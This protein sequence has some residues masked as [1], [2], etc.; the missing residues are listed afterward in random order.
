[1]AGT[2][3]EVHPTKLG[4]NNRKDHKGFINAPKS[5]TDAKTNHS[6]T[7]YTH[8]YSRKRNS[9]YA[10]TNYITNNNANANTTNTNNTQNQALW[11]ESLQ[12]F[13]NGAFQKAE[14][15]NDSQKTLF[16]EQ[17]QSLIY[18]AARDKKI[19]TNDWALQKLPVFVPSVPL[20][21]VQDTLPPP[22]P[23]IGKPQIQTSSFN[24]KQR[25]RQR[26]E[27]F[28]SNIPTISSSP[29]SGTSTKQIIGTLTAL[30][31]RYLRLTSEPVPALVRPELVLRKSLD[32][33]VNKFRSTACLYLYI[34]D[35][36][37]A[38]RQDLTVQHIKNDLT[39]EVYETHG[40]I[41]IENDDLGEFNQC[42]S[43][44][45]QLYSA[46]VLSDPTYYTKT[47]EFACYRIL[48]LLLTGNYSS[49]ITSK[50][51]VMDLDSKLDTNNLAPDLAIYKQCL[52]K[53][54]SLLTVL[55]L[56]S[57]H[58]FFQIYRWFKNISIPNSAFHL[59]DKFMAPKQR[60][61]ALNIMSKAFKKLSLEYI[62]EQLAIDSPIIFLE[63]YGLSPF[64]DSNSFDMAA[65][66]SSLQAIVDRGT[67]K[68]VD[69]KGQV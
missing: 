41:A 54:L 24:S 12:D 58:S 31:K 45:S 18:S 19:W 22:A 37:K 13:V 33:V 52:N 35:Q 26:A 42:Q 1:M 15:L 3:N 53:A 44:L 57:Y 56:N 21:L 69:I 36:L 20:A 68:K 9:D 14:T 66:K 62:S 38:I 64:A 47:Y 7:G 59:M 29:P 2:Y 60:L 63:E 67:F 17:I 40:R 46:K 50:M 23:K 55:T 16:K 6:N 10:N 25:K 51:E 43:Q 34:N 27:R 4:R 11:P 49:V 28:Q 39:I 8:T 48:Y 65:A 32:F 61:L 30:E 5:T